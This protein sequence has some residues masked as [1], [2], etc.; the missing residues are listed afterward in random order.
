MDYR[1]L[2]ASG[3]EV[4]PLCLGTMDFGNSADETTA[5]RII[6]MAR[7]RGVNFIDTA[8]V[9]ARGESE[10]IIG[11]AIRRER[12]RWIVAT[13]VGN[14]MGEAV[15]E[16]DMSRRWILRAIDDSLR[17][18]ATD[19]LDLY[20]LDIDDG[21]TPLEETIG[22]LGDLIRQGKVRHWGFSNFAAWRIAEMIGVSKD[23]GVPRPVAA[24]PCYNAVTRTAERD[25]LPACAHFGIAVVPYSPL[26]RG[27]LTGKYAPGAAPPKGSR[28]G[29]GDQ[30]I[31]ETE[32][33]EESLII[34][35]R[36]KARAARRHMTAA[37][38]A[39]GWILNNRLVTSVVAGPRTARQ[40]AGYLGALGRRFSAEDEAFV[41]GLVRPGDASTP[42]YLDPRYPVSG[43]QPIEG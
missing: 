31:L 32:F 12:D 22:T 1:K 24:Q 38:F 7:D 17:R 21:T 42:G 30:R 4:S 5:R 9:N 16:R 40:W 26:A 2:G 37:Q 41:D 18:L 14:A 20:Y 23:L 43:R 10:R 3:L 25:T 27:V 13:K 6:A 34:A 15:S 29:R 33:R 36:I 35:R 11:R 39:V 28:A 19:Y 8:D